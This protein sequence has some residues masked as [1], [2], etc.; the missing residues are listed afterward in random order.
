MAE[1]S[2]RAQALVDSWADLPSLSSQDWSEVCLSVSAPFH[3][4]GMFLLFLLGVCNLQ[5]DFVFVPD[6]GLKDD[7]NP[8]EDWEIKEEAVKKN[9]TV[10][11]MSPD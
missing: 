9:A 10:I 6:Q 5:D 7:E 3:V 8:R 1:G 4:Q 2:N 11:L